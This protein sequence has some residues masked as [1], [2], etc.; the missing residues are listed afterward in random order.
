MQVFVLDLDPKKAALYHNDKHIV[1]MPTESAQILCTVH[2]L[3]SNRTDIPY[4]KTHIHHPC[5]KW[6]LESLSNYNWLLSLLYEQLKE[7]SYRYE[8][9]HAT[10]RVYDWLL[11]NKP[12]LPNKEMTPF[13]LVMPEQYITNDPVQSYRNFYIGDKFYFSKYKK[14]NFPEWFNILN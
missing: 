6:V 7:Y 3:I 9:V 12:N 1:K 14:R 11:Q 13:A 5:V 8:R 10:Q 4:R 2:H